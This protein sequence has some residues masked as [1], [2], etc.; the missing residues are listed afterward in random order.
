MDEQKQESKQEINPAS[1]KTYMV[2]TNDEISKYISRRYFNSYF[3]ITL[4]EKL[5]NYAPFDFIDYV[6]RKGPNQNIKNLT[7]WFNDNLPFAHDNILI[8][9][10]VH[11]DNEEF[12]PMNVRM[13]ITVQQIR[14]I[15]AYNIDILAV[16]MSNMITEMMHCLMK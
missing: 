7:D 6:L 16:S 13:Q 8:E 11:K 15:K 10:V 12:T 4:H 3:R 2:Y 5:S 1:L 14:D 9:L